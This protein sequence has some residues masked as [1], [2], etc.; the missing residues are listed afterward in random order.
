MERTRK[1]LE[2]DQMDRMRKR[3][4]LMGVKEFNKEMDT[5]LSQRMQQEKIE[6]IKK[7]PKPLK[8][9]AKKYTHG[10][11]WHKEEDGRASAEE[12]HSVVEGTN[13]KQPVIGGGLMK[14]LF[15]RQEHPAKQLLRKTEAR[16]Q[17]LA[18]P[19]E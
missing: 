16:F 19:L 18:P 14:N 3:M 5:Q 15:V 4:D 2:R 10:K 11:G 9:K 7:D 6:S 13:E 8:P 1:A 12:L 17:H